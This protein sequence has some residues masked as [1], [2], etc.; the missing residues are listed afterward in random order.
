MSNGE[1]KKVLS[2]SETKDF[3]T[4]SRQFE[5]YK[6]SKPILEIV[7]S[8][9]FLILSTVICI[10][11]GSI[12][13]M[14]SG[15]DVKE[16]AT[17]LR[18]GYDAYDVYSLAGAFASLGSLACIIPSVAI[19]T[20][21]VKSRPFHSVSSSCGGFSFKIFFKVL[22]PA[23]IIVGIPTAIEAASISGGRGAIQFTVLGFIACLILGPLQCMGEE[24]MFRGVLLQGIGSWVKVPIIAIILQTL[25]FAYLHPY[26]V[27]GVIEVCLSGL[28]MG[29]AAYY[30]KGLETSGAYHIVNNMVLFM[31]NGFG[32][33]TISKNSSQVKDIILVIVLEGAYLAVV[34]LLD[35]KF[36][37]FT[38]T[39]KEDDIV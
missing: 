2:R 35:K 7:L 8:G 39:P 28:L 12:I 31:M 29:L 26:G 17:N 14:V 36:N 38:R 16:F 1:R 15:G 20:K 23:L 24:Y 33:K 19:I 11:I 37:W 10:G 4:Y 13:I 5:G 6:W 22:V 18:K 34:L 3:V 25:V 9:L 27:I 32:F 30:T 21:L